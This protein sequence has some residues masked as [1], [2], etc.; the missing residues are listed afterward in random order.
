MPQG[1]N[2]ASKTLSKNWT[3]I[4]WR[5]SIQLPI[6]RKITLNETMRCKQ[7]NSNWE[8]LTIQFLQEIN[9]EEKERAKESD[10]EGWEGEAYRLKI[11]S[12]E[13]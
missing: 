12:N 9:C 10:R 11:V 4:S 2:V 5:L 6:Y 13:L 7:Q 3:L 1:H 8:T